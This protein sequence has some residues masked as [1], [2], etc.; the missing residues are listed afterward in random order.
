M[1]KLMG[2]IF[3]ALAVGMLGVGCAQS[4]ALPNACMVQAIHHQ[5]LVQT[6]QTV[7]Q[8][9]YQGALT[10]SFLDRSVGHAVSVYER[11]GKLWAYDPEQGAKLLSGRKGPAWKDATHLARLVFPG[12]SVLYAAWL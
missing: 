4:E 3:L 6:N 12:E 7:R 11:N 5:Q 10:V 8:R 2:G 9:G 1:K